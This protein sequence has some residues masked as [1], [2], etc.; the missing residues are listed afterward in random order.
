M[1]AKK[2]SLKA[3]RPLLRWFRSL[4]TVTRYSFACSAA[5]LTTQT[6]LLMKIVIRLRGV[7]S[8]SPLTFTCRPQK[9][10]LPNGKEVRNVE[11]LSRRNPHRVT[12]LCSTGLRS[13]GLLWTVSAV[14]CSCAF[15]EAD[16]PQLLDTRAEATIQHPLKH[17]NV[18][19]G[20]AGEPLE[21]LNLWERGTKTGFSEQHTVEPLFIQ[22]LPTRPALV[23]EVSASGQASLIDPRRR[24][25]RIVGEYGSEL[26]FVALEPRMG[27]MALVHPARV[28]IID[29]HTGEEAYG[30]D[31]L[32]VRVN[33]VAFEPMGDTI[34]CGAAD[35]RVYRWKFIHESGATTSRSFE[36]GL[37]R[38]IGH[39]S[40]VS[41]VACH[42]QGRVF[43]SGDWKGKLN[44]WLGYDADAFGGE[45]DKN[46]TRGRIFTAEVTR[47]RA[48]GE[49]QGSIEKLLVSP[50]G[51]LLYVVTDKGFL[52]VWR[53][54]GFRRLVQVQAHD[55]LIYDA[56]LSPSG[57]SIS[58]VGRDGFVREWKLLVTGQEEGDPV[59]GE[60]REFQKW[61]RRD[62]R[63]LAYISEAELVGGMLSGPTENLGTGIRNESE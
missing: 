25:R 53:V 57:T 63:K 6:P 21:W 61:E 58:T 39:A 55:G 26:R 45:Y 43:F 10:P 19:S 27:R 11:P 62:V 34:I 14:L 42:P 2:I 59:E 32:K 22:T 30:L 24:E 48:S 5:P 20:K 37:E 52:Q 51:E 50:D 38:Y 56:A 15:H 17:S 40:V 4:E 49:V 1:N 12:S 36:R 33:S 18:V 54:R 29:L 23:F 9:L 31:K 7:S 46:A 13:I 41:A 60:L 44:A 47:V 16:K 3:K 8:K 35:G 28:A